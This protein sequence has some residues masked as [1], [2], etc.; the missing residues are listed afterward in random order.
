[1]PESVQIRIHGDPSQPTLIYLPG[2][3]GNWA[4][5][6]PFRCLLRDRLRFVEISYPSTLNW[7]LED[8]AEAVEAALAKHGITNGWLLGESF[9]SQ[10]LWRL[11]ARKRFQPEGAILAGGFVRHPMRWAVRLA[12][13]VSGDISLRLITR[14]L[15]GYAKVSRFRFRRSPEVL[16]S[17]HE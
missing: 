17:I 10:V 2:L 14:L 11:L 16:A 8:Y 13:R 15:L 5:I 7:S 6:G 9:S 4:F 12:V 3:H 1:M